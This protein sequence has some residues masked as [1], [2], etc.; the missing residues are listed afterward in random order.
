MLSLQLWRAL[1]TTFP[2]HPLFWQ[3]QAVRPT[4]R[5]PRWVLWTRMLVF[6][7]LVCGVLWLL[8]FALAIIIAVVY[9]VPFVGALLIGGR[10]AF[11]VSSSITREQRNGRYELAALAPSGAFGAAWALATRHLRGD[12]S[13]I[14]LRRAIIILQGALFALIAVISVVQIS[15]VINNRYPIGE[16]G[17]DDLL[18]GLIA[19][20]ILHIDLWQ[21]LLTG[22]LL[23]V[24]MP[25]Y[26]SARLDT[27]LATLG[28]FMGIQIGI[29][30][31][32]LFSLS[33]FNTLTGYE[34][35]LPLV[36]VGL[37]LMLSLHELALHVIWDKLVQQLNID[38]G[39]LLAWR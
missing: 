25:T 26:G 19:I 27:A 31:I 7:V 37:I 39:A 10:T 13:A 11:G 3:P 33:I 14:Q 21:A 17:F 6:I 8:P 16:S 1:F 34:S 2:R 15:N 32:V 36:I 5:Y 35:A 29:Y 20:A 18:T 23:G 28:I 30:V 38:D 12:R 4:R 24:L 9:L 22:A